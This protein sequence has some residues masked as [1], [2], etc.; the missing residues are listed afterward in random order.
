MTGLIAPAGNFPYR[1]IYLYNNSHTYSITLKHQNASSAA[2]N[3]FYLP[4]SVDYVLSQG[5]SCLLMYDTAISRW[6]VL[7]K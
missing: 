4:G 2:A 1:L 7:D 6:V 5:S 3:R